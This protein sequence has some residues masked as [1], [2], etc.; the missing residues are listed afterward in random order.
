MFEI[1]KILVPTDFSDNASYAYHPAHQLANRFGSKIDLIHIIP[2][3]QYFSES[4]GNLGVPFSMEKDLYP[5]IQKESLHKINKLMEEHINEE[6]QGESVVRIAPR[7]SKAIVEYAEEEGCDLIVM[8]THGKNESELLRGS[9]TEKVIRYSDIPVLTTDHSSMED[10]ENILVPTDGSER[11]MQALTMAVSLALTFDASITLYHVLELHG[12]LTENIEQDPRKSEMDNIH[13]ML[14]AVIE[15]FFEQSWDKVE[16]RRGE[17][18]VDQLVY[19]EHASNATINMNTV[20]EKGVSAHYAIRE[21]AEEHS[22][23]VVMTT[24]GHSGLAHLLLGSTA[25]KVTQHMRKPVLTV[26]PTLEEKK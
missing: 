2:T 10:I 4:I 5:K 3:L 7:A 16:V 23:L 22:D 12:S 9:V 6:H 26:K 20:I 11:S 25:E 1:N 8:A 14:M 19:N 15:S 17:G 24:H 13:D 21:Y 18:M